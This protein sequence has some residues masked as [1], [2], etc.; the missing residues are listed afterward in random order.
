LIGLTS[1]RING[2]A[3]VAPKLNR[4]RA[5]F[6][7]TK[8]DEILIWEK[9]I[10]RE[11]DTRF[12][13]SVGPH[14]ARTRPSVAAAGTAP[15]ERSGS[16]LTGNRPKRPRLKLEPEPYRQLCRKVLERDGWRCQSCG[17][18][19]GLQVHHIHPRSRLGDDTAENLIALCV[20]CHQK[21]HR[22]QKDT[23]Q[24]CRTH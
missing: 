16:P 19:E 24:Y 11:R 8:I 18:I 6:V 17:Q 21:A 14:S 9:A 7:L 2:L 4:R 12:A 3:M 22:L 15:R 20:L 23:E 13:S 10:N 5:L 1:L